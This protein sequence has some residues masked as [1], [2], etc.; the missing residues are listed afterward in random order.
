VKNLFLPL[1]GLILFS[2]AGTGEKADT[3]SP[4]ISYDSVLN[5][6]ETDSL[7]RD[8][9]LRD[10]INGSPNAMV[11]QKENGLRIEWQVKKEGRKITRW[12][13][14]MINYKARVAGGEQYDSNDGVGWA[15]PVRIGI[16]ILVKGMEEG[17]AEMHEGDKGRIMIPN[18]LAYGED[19]YGTI[20]PPKADVIVDL[21][22]VDLL[23]PYSLEEGIKVFKWHVSDSGK[24]AKKNQWIT[25]D[26]FAYTQGDAGKMYDNSYQNGEPY[27]MRFQ[28]DNL[29]AGLHVG[30]S[31]LKPGDN[32]L[33]HIPAKMAYGTK[34]MLDLVPPNT[35]IIYDVRVL[36]IR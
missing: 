30:M 22:I 1:C 17:L 14:P 25:F 36:S 4:D 35:D 16:G 19:G 13:V 7:D 34:G 31:V 12:D 9:L 28:N 29:V 3:D 21:E 26:Y 18:A 23:E 5:S 11:L 10:S 33:I 27:K 24:V 8:K 15:V 20:V 2:C 6:N 32:A